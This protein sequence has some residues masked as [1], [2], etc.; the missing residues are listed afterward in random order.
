MT[1]HVQEELLLVHW[2]WDIMVNTDVIHK[3][4]ALQVLGY[5]LPPTTVSS[6][7]SFKRGQVTL[8]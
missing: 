4:C 5:E 3:Q 8:Y 7:M 1:A 6:N 2:S